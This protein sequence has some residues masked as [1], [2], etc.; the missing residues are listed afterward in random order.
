MQTAISNSFASLQT[1]SKNADDAQA[2]LQHVDDVVDKPTVQVDVDKAR[3]DDS[4]PSPT[5]DTAATA[6]VTP[7]PAEPSPATSLDEHAAS[8]PTTPQSAKPGAST[9]G[10]PAS[11]HVTS[12]KVA[13]PRKKVDADGDITVPDVDTVGTADTSSAV[14]V[15]KDAQQEAAKVATPRPAKSV[16]D[17]TASSPAT[18]RS[19]RMQT[20]VSSG[21]MRQKSVAEIM[22][23]TPKTANRRRASTLMRGQ[24]SVTHSPLQTPSRITHDSMPPPTPRPAAMTMFTPEDRADDGLLPFA[25]EAYSALSGAAEDPNRDYLEPLYRIQAQDPPNGRSLVELLHKASKSISTSDQ[26]VCYRERQDHRILKRVYGLQYANHWSLRQMQPCAEPP[27]PKTHWDHVI[28]EAKWMRTDFRQERKVKKAQAKFYAEACAAWV[29]ANAQDRLQMQVKVITPA[30][31]QVTNKDVDAPQS[32]AATHPE[33][34]ESKDN[35]EES[36]P[37]L[38]MSDKDDHSSPTDVDSPATPQFA[39]VPD[40]VF[41]AMNVSESTAHLVDSED[42]TRAINDLPLYVPFDEEDGMAHPSKQLVT[43]PVPSVSKFSSDKIIAKV[44]N[45]SRKRSRFDYE[46]GC[47]FDGPES[48]RAR[49]DREASGLA[50]EQTDIALFDDEHKAI[51]ERLRVSTSFRPPSEFPMPSEKFYEWRLSSHWTWEDDQKIRKL[52]KDFCF[53]WSLVADQMALPSHFHPA[54]DRRTPWECFERWVE[55]E[56]LPNDMRKTVYFRTWS[57]RMETASRQVEARY[58]A[59]LQL[60]SQNGNPTQPPQK[61]KTMPMRVERRR[62]GRYL[63]LVDA[64]RKLARKREQQQHKQAEAQKAASMRKQLESAPSKQVVHTPAEF[65]RLRHERDLQMQARNERMREAM[66]AQQKV[67]RNRDDALHTRT[68][69]L[70]AAQMQ[71]AGQMPNQQAL[72]AAQQQRQGNAQMAQGQ[73]AQMQNVGHQAQMAGQAQHH[74]NMPVQNRNGQMVP[75]MGMQG[76]MAQ[77]QMQANMRANNGGQN[78]MSQEQIQR[79]AMQAQMKGNAMQNMQQ[80]KQFQQQL[81]SQGGNANMNGMMNG[82]MNSNQAALL[83]AMQANQNGMGNMQHHGNQMNGNANSSVSP[84]MAPPN[85]AQPKQLSSGHIPAINQIKHSLQAQHPQATPAQID[86]MANEHMKRHIQTTQAR[87]NAANAASGNY[88]NVQ[89]Q[90]AFQQN[91]GIAGQMNNF[92][93]NGSQSQQQQY[94]QMMRQRLLQQAQQQ[95]SQQQMQQQMQAQGQTLASSAS[96][97]PQQASPA[98]THASPVAQQAVPNMANG[99][100]MNIGAHVNGQQRP[101]SRNNTPQ[102]ARIPS[103]G[104]MGSPGMGQGSPRPQ[105]VKQG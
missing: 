84:N 92:N 93:V 77:A 42:F 96:P 33:Q 58:H 21:A 39:F 18:D 29:A 54:A 47:G 17:K 2:D 12:S 100:N 65:S 73:N 35:N 44:P 30:A 78:Q 102:M 55:L 56:T 20:R 46:D 32:P 86:Q 4:T 38:D 7:R 3:Q 6:G 28:A 90:M 67:H 98:N 25:M 49:P 66:L 62:T 50:P 41:S 76:N 64:M 63:H 36:V 70:Q 22:K 85:P 24:T 43:A 48:K 1:K 69:L 52:A 82:Q 72:L 88:G 99:M 26:L 53:N 80:M 71:R 95:Q 94:S 81:M 97:R 19:Q 8:H 68:D 11:E 75:Q 74:G 104:G 13:T 14:P 16:Q 10:P 27:V 61:R 91:G 59:Q 105:M 40:V 9:D 37:E 89:G 45:S 83:A 57:Q 23:E 87:Q 60:H 31:E 15:D 5:S 51:K 79:L 34:G 101:P 103:S